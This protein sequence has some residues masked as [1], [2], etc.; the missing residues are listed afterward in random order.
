L[1]PERCEDEEVELR[2]E[3]EERLALLCEAPG[4]DDAPREDV[5]ELLA[6][7]PEIEPG[8]PL[9]RVRALALRAE[10]QRFWLEA[11]PTSALAGPDRE[12]SLRCRLELL[13]TSAAACGVVRE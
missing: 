9:G 12:T 5:P 4:D 8:P 2:P 1:W 6:L 13:A 10:Y 3:P 11:R 7:R